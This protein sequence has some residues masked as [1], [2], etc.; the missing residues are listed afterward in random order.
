[1]KQLYYKQQSRKHAVKLVLT[2]PKGNIF[3]AVKNEQYFN[4]YGL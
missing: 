3:L 1:M 4:Y 2:I